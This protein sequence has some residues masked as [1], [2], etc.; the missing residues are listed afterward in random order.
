MKL[1]CRASPANST[2]NIRINA[3]HYFWTESI[4]MSM[5]LCS[6]ATRSFIWIFQFCCCCCAALSLCDI[7]N[8]Q[9][10]QI[11]IIIHKFLLFPY[12]LLLCGGGWKTLSGE[13]EVVIALSAASDEGGAGVAARTFRSNYGNVS[14]RRRTTMEFYSQRN[15]FTSSLNFYDARSRSTWSCDLYALA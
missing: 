1:I 9:F 4:F 10:T 7:R 15:D 14:C 5:N 8:S 11:T 13:S 3:K 2:N 12:H 6:I